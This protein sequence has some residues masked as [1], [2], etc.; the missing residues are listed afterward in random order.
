MALGDF[1]YYNL[2]TTYKTYSTY[3]PR[4]S[5]YNSTVRAPCYSYYYH[6]VDMGY[7]GAV[8][9]Y[10]YTL[11]N[12]YYVYSYRQLVSTYYKSYTPTAYGT[13]YSYYYHYVPPAF[14]GD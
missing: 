5:T 14:V 4:Y 10:Y 2:L 6:L 12:T 7:M 1:Y 13:Y 11:E 8:I 3:G 9:W